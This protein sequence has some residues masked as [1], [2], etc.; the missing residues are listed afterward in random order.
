MRACGSG[1]YL[2]APPPRKK[3][4]FVHCAIGDGRYGAC[5]LFRPPRWKLFWQKKGTTAPL[6]G[7]ALR[8]LRP[9]RPRVAIAGVLGGPREVPSS[10]PRPRRQVT[11]SC[12]PPSSPTGLYARRKRLDPNHTSHFCPRRGEMAR[13]AVLSKRRSTWSRGS[14]A[15][16]PFYC[17]PL[18]YPLGYEGA[19]IR[20][21]HQRREG[22]CKRPQA[23]LSP[24]AEANSYLPT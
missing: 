5:A 19:W 10:H 12:S 8:S 4:E 13:P 23:V 2:P 21:L 16:F 6:K 14:G 15:S 22:S 11:G 18:L 20:S 9:P 17:A 24:L 7:P 3:L 1:S